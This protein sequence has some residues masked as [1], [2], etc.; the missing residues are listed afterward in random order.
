MFIH[1]RNSHINRQVAEDIKVNVHINR[2]GAQEIKLNVYINRQVVHKTKVSVDI[3]AK[4]LKLSKLV[5]I[6][7]AR[8]FKKPNESVKCYFLTYTYEVLIPAIS[9]APSIKKYIISIANLLKKSVSRS[10]KFECS[11][12]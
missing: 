5:C 7:I 12:L 3:I 10:S 8:L 1:L 6:L 2:K 9:I 11:G 4:L